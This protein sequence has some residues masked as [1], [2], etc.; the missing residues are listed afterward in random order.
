VWRTLSTRVVFSHPRHEVHEDE[1]A[2]PDGRTVSY[3]KVH[4]NG[5]SVNVLCRRDD[6]QILLQREYSYPPNRIMLELP[7]GHVP[8]GEDPETGANRELMEEAGYRA[9]RLTLL[10]EYF[11]NPRRSDHR[12]LVYLAEDLVEASLPGDPE[13]QIEVTWV[14]EAEVDTLIRQGEIVNL[15]ILAAWSLY[16]AHAARA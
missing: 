16:R 13:E 4:E 11:M 7:G 15:S 6:G 8:E 3:I 5:V 10:G 12:M 9:G 2:L 1:V 14:S